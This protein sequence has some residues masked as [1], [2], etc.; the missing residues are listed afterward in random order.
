MEEM[1]K[2]DIFVNNYIKAVT[3]KDFRKGMR[4]KDFP[5]KSTELASKIFFK[6]FKD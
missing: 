3:D 5:T 4:L 6:V 1:E 2:L